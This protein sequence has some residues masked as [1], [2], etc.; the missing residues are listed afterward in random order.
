[1]RQQ[2]H[3]EYRS[4]GWNHLGLDRDLNQFKLLFIKPCCFCVIVEQWI[5][6]EGLH[7][8]FVDTVASRGLVVRDVVNT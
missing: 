1:V 3:G 5:W 7:P 6:C 4:V 8:V 2:L